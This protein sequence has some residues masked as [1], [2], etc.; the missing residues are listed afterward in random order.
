MALASNVVATLSLL[1]SYTALW[2]KLGIGRKVLICSGLFSISSGLIFG[3]SSGH[4]RTR[5]AGVPDN[6][7]SCTGAAIA[8]STDH[9]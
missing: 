1:A 9:E 7:A 5:D 2:A 8:V 4:V 3:P 6:V